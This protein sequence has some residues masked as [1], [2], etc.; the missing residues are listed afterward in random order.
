ME[1]TSEEITS[2]NERQ[3]HIMIIDDVRVNLHILAA[4]IKEMG[5]FPDTYLS[6]KE[7]IE[8]L[9]TATPQ[10]I[11]LDLMMPDMDGIEFCR[12]V[13]QN[14]RLRDI[15]VIFISAS[16]DTKD[17]EAGF[18]A[19]AVDYIT[20]PFDRS[21]V[22]SRL[23]IHIK[24]YEMSLKLEMSNSRLN[25]L[26]VEQNKKIEEE[27]KHLLLALAKVSESR[28][29]LTKNHISNVQYNSRILAQGLQLSTQF[30]K[31][32]SN[33]FI[34]T[35]EVASAL[36][37]IG[38]ITIPDQVLLKT[39]KLN[40]QERS[41]ISRH[42]DYGA[43]LLGEISKEIGDNEF[44]DMAV[45]IARYHHENWD[46]SGYPYGLKGHQ[47]PLCARI[48][49]IVDVYDV[50]LGQRSYKEAVEEEDAITLMM[51]S[52]GREFDPDIMKVFGKI[53]K[54]LKKD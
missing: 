28:D 37:D 18:E 44:M 36:H 35:I 43:E 13:K 45:E 20:Q 46:G 29:N 22:K 23:N 26:V 34:E 6:A 21:E 15:P 50:L 41:S 24:M 2:S 3:I 31:E 10:L 39:D 54:R 33:W 30:E 4:L 38:M 40:E 12:L 52:S 42:P 51:E 11:L 5:Y 49:R 14:V 19:G 8:A 25:R 27:K 16:G 17:K 9:E 7:A 53:L 32:I 1:T 48:V 47:I